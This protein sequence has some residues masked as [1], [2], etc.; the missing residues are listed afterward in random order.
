MDAGWYPCPCCDGEGGSH[1]APLPD[2]KAEI[3]RAYDLGLL[4]AYVD[5]LKGGYGHLETEP[6]GSRGHAWEPSRDDPPAVV[7][8]EEDRHG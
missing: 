6:V 2:H 3:L 7:A 8:S 1:S 5:V 4:L